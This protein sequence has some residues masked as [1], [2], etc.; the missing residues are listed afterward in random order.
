MRVI[1]EHPAS[2]VVGGTAPELAFRV[3]D[4]RDDPTAGTAVFYLLD[5]GTRARHTLAAAVAIEDVEVRTDAASGLQFWSFVL[6]ATLETVDLAVDVGLWQV[7][8]ELTMAD[9]A[10]ATIPAPGRPAFIELLPSEEE[11]DMTLGARTYA[12][13]GHTLQVGDWVYRT[14]AGL[15]ASAQAD[16]GDTLAEGLVTSTAVDAVTVFFG[17]VLE[18]TSHGKGAVGATLYLSEDTAGGERTDAPD[19]GNWTQTLGTVVTDDQLHVNID[20]GIPS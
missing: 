5:G 3:V 10:V 13:P 8:A 6:R 19:P 2:F 17:G 20:A 9:G 12:Q 15:W 1:P 14:G 4:F 11:E 16:D 18:Y 7:R